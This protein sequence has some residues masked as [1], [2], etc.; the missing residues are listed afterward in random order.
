MVKLWLVVCKS[1]CLLNLFL[2]VGLS[3]PFGNL[4]FIPLVYLN[5]TSEEALKCVPKTASK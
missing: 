3:C 1:S 4:A 5:L 2:P